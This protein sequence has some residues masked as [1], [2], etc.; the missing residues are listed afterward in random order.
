[1]TSVGTA[2]AGPTARADSSRLPPLGTTNATTVIKAPGTAF[3]LAFLYLAVYTVL[4]PQNRHDTVF[5]VEHSTDAGRAGGA[6]FNHGISG[7]GQ[8]SAQLRLW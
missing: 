2:I 5:H 8:G 4:S 7:P 1:M 6:P 3:R